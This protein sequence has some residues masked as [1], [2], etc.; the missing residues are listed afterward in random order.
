MNNLDN[1][2]I[3]LYMEN[4]DRYSLLGSGGF[5]LSTEIYE[6]LERHV[7]KGAPTNHQWFLNMDNS[8]YQWHHGGLMHDAFGQ[9]RRIFYFRDEARALMFKLTWGGV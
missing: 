2:Y 5:Q 7:G 8:Q 3:T 6:W 9:L 1:T 4:Q